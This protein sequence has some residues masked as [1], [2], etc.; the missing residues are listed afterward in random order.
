MNTARGALVD[1]V[2]LASALREGR[3]RAAALDV[4]E[5]EPF[6]ISTGIFSFSKAFQRVDQKTC[7]G[8][9]LLLKIL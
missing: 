6:D 3:L 4:H 8:N 1:E 2:A 7:S 5:K 9:L